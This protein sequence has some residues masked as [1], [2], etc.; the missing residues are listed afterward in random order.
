MNHKTLLGGHNFLAYCENFKKV[1]RRKYKKFA[2]T[3]KAASAKSENSP[4]IIVLISIK[5]CYTEQKRGYAKVLKTPQRCNSAEG[6]RLKN[7]L[8]FFKQPKNMDIF[9]FLY[10]LFYGLPL[11]VVQVPH[12]VDADENRNLKYSLHCITP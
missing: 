1:R 8:L 12:W 4:Q 9:F 7:V 11:G 5:V 3:D 2:P 6:K 10:Y